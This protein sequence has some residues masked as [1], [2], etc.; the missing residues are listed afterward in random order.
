MTD[1]SIA[2]RLR[3]EVGQYVEGMSRAAKATDAVGEAGQKSAEKSTR[4][5][6]G[7]AKVAADNEREWRRTGTALVAVGTGVAAVGAAA[8]KAGIDYNRLQQRSRAAL[9]TL[10]GD[11]KAANA[12]MDKLDEFA[13]TSPFSKQTFISAQQQMLAF[14]I[15]AQKVI[16]YLDAIQ[17]AVAASGGSNDDI[18]GIVATLS[19]VQSSAKITAEDLNELGNRGVNAA[20]LI[21]SQMG[22]TGADVRTAISKGA[23]DAGQALDALAAGMSQR[24]DGAAENV[25]TTF[26][27][28]LDRVKAAWRDLGSALAEPLVG[29]NGGGL[30]TSLLNEVADSMRA[31]EDLPGPAKAAAVGVAGVGAAGSLAAG[32]FLLLVPK[33][34]EYREAVADLGPRGQAAAS[35]LGRLGKAASVSLIALAGYQS[36]K[37]IIPDSA[38]ASVERYGAALLDLSSSSSGKSLDELF[39]VENSDWSWILAAKDGISGLSDAFKALDVSVGDRLARIPRFGFFDNETDLAK[40]SFEQADA[41]LAQFVS[42][43]NAEQAAKQYEYIKRTAE[44]AG[45]PLKDLA[46]LFPQ[47]TDSLTGM[48]NEQRLAG[49]SASTLAGGMQQTAEE[50][51]AAEEAIQKA[52]EAVL[53]GGDAFVG[54]GEDVNNAKVPLDD[55]LRQLEEQNKAL[56][57]FADNAIAAGKN[58]LEKGLI[59]QLAEMGPEGALRMKQLADASEEEI[60]RANAAFLAG[61]EGPDALADAIDSIPDTQS[62]D[63][64]VTVRRAIEGVRAVQRAIDSMTGRTIGIRVAGPG[65][66]GMTTADADGGFHING[67]KRRAGGGFDEK[68]RPVQRVSQIR[69]AAQGAVLWGEAETGWEAYISGK[70]GMTKRNQGIAAEAVERLGGVAMFADGGITD[71]SNKLDT[72]RMR[73]RIRDLQRDLRETETYGS[74]KKKRRRLRL[75]GLDRVEAQYELQ[76]ARAEYAATLRANRAQRA[77]GMSLDAFN[78]YQRDRRANSDSFRDRVSIDGL[79]TPAAVE[80]SLERQIA[81]MATLTSLLIALKQKGAAPWLLQQL[82]SAGPS[83]TAIRLARHYLADT[84]A[85][86]SVN[87]QAAQLQ[88]VSSLY[89]QVTSDPRWSAAGAWSGGLTA[90]QSKQLQLIVQTTDQSTIANVV[91]QVVVHEV[92][93]MLQT[94]AGV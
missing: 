17:N 37:A 78:D 18:S 30:L 81:D 72:L 53:S 56:A 71:A 66:G 57:D 86:A 16:P 58:G 69:Q 91:R 3:A 62:T 87:A 55:W 35:A 68:G 45:Y 4:S 11:A 65:G 79:S 8:A 93:P 85:L 48:S 41:A 2:V 36:I 12:Q 10:L 19:K 20:E 89:G 63:V 80:R 60:A 29:K 22:L 33:L 83:K 49:E 94:G 47:Y 28:A 5:F 92:M 59:Q 88:Q 52:R 84:T 51:K 73:I 50:A 54:F 25:K 90:S 76:D 13:K 70:P 82:Q 23:L 32:G 61:T 7:L 14:G 44:E 9:T 15:E 42:S 40:K 1:R 27:G 26:D 74:G 75:R 21:G 39:T 67:V 31:L 6:T 34:V 38:I 46:G 77:S 43:G 64:T 24:F